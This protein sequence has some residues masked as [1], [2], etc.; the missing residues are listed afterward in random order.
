MIALASLASAWPAIGAVV[1]ILVG[2][3]YARR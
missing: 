1:G 3:V 2:F